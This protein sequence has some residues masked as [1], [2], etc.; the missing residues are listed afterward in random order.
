MKMKTVKKISFVILFAMIFSVAMLTLSVT[1]ADDEAKANP[2]GAYVKLTVNVSKKDSQDN[3]NLAYNFYT[4][5]KLDYV[6]QEGDMLEYDVYTSIEERGWGAIDGEVTTLGTLR[7]AGLSDIDGNGVH[8]GTDL[9]SYC[10]EQWYHRIIPFGITED[11]SDNFTV[12]RTLKKI[13]IAMHPEGDENDYQG[14]ALYD[15][16]V[17]T[18]NGEV[19]LVIF[20][21]AADYVEADVRFSHSM[22]TDKGLVECLTFT[23]QEEQAFKD[24]E[25]AK[26]KEIASREEAK[27]IAEAEKEASR[28]QASKDAAIAESEAAANSTAA[29]DEPTTA[30]NSSDD[31]GNRTMIIIMSAVGGLLVIVVIIVIITSISKKKKKS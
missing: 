25:E 10:Y 20:K 23:A 13:M 9:S 17:I 21:D 18:N 1:A 5:K 4:L 29:I 19:K 14:F 28:E 31:G 16:I 2:V 11:E 12:G 8:T 30:A 22:G 24:A 7:D 6:I 27:S 26:I 15:N 3:P